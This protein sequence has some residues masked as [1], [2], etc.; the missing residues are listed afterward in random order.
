VVIGQ[1]KNGIT[2]HVIL[3]DGELLPENLN[4]PKV[5]VYRRGESTGRELLIVKPLG[6]FATE[7]L[8][9][10][11]DSPICTYSGDG[12][13]LHEHVDKTWWHYDE[14]WTYENGPFETYEQAYAALEAY[15]TN[16]Q[17]TKEIVLTKAEE[18]DRM[19]VDEFLKQISGSPADGGGS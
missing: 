1:G 4:N 17:K 7:E 16:L 5:V 15:C 14:S 19:V 12:N 18:T 8:L 2:A 9:K 10:K 6:E 13:P 3:A 11:P